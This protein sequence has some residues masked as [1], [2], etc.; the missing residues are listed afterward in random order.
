MVKDFINYCPK[1]FESGEDKDTDEWWRKNL[2]IDVFKKSY[3]NIAASY[4]KVGD[5]SMSATHIQ[6]TAKGNLPYLSYTFHNPKPLGN[7]S[8]HSPVMLQ[9]TCCSLKYIERSKG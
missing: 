3:K 2:L 4:L 1:G 9:R 6:T 5:D 8:T 7:S